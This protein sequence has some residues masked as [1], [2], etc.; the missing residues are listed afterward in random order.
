MLSSME[1]ACVVLWG[2]SALIFGVLACLSWPQNTSCWRRS[3]RGALRTGIGVAASSVQ[4]RDEN[5]CQSAP[6]L[7]VETRE[8]SDIEIKMLV[9]RLEHLTIV[10]AS[11]EGNLEELHGEVSS[12]R[13]GLAI[14]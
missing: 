3:D 13:R 14:L 11:L 8:A 12:L 6:L 10:V 1:L 7:K 4:G 5:R 2:L 9:Q